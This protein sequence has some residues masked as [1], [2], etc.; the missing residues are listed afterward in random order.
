MILLVIQRRIYCIQTSYVHESMKRQYNVW[1][2]SVENFVCGTDE[3]DTI[4]VLY[5]LQLVIVN[6]QG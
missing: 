2:V 6:N 1:T 5:I 3:K 4:A